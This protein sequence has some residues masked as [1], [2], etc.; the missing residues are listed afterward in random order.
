MQLKGQGRWFLP[1]GIGLE[2]TTVKG[3]RHK[4]AERRFQEG[5]EPEPGWVPLKKD[6][7]M[8]HCGE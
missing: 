1:Q 7:N 5:D 8:D 4:D 6:Y 2:T 3:Q